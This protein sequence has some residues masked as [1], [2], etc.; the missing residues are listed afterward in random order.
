MLQLY[1]L[2]FAM[3]IEMK[4]CISQILV[5]PHHIRGINADLPAALSDVMTR[6]D[7]RMLCLTHD[8]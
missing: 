5:N 8:P 6:T 2:I 7:L 3:V 4:G 1:L